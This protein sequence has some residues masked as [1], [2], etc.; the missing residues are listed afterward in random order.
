M[1]RNRGSEASTVTSGPSLDVHPAIR[2]LVRDAP[3]PMAVIDLDGHAWIWNAA[4]ETLFPPPP[5]NSSMSYPLFSLGTQPWF[6][7]VRAAGVSGRGSAAQEWRPRG[8]GGARYR[9]RLS[10]I[11]VRGSNQT[12]CALIVQLND[13][14]AEERRQKRAWRRAQRAQRVL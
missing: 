8:L 9:L 3:V 5:R 14:T 11:P 4:A 7:E 2:M 1:N 10:L 13:Q 12:V 6:E